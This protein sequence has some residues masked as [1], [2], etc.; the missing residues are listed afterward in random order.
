MINSGYKLWKISAIYLQREFLRFL[1]KLHKYQ[2]SVLMISMVK[3]Y[4]KPEIMISGSDFTD[5]LFKKVNYSIK[6][7]KN[8]CSFY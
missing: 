4:N 3:F 8:S 7:S 2:K 6:W 5:T 1:K